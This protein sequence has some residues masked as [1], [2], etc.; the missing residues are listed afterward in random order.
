VHREHGEERP[1]HGRRER[2][3]DRLRFAGGSRGR[4]LSERTDALG[5]LFGCHPEARGPP[6]DPLQDAIAH[7]DDRDELACEDNAL[8]DEQPCEREDGRGESERRARTTTSADH[9][10]P[11][12][13]FSRP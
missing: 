4:L 13:G 1:E 8:R 6:T 7:A 11:S 10:T 5:Q 12:L 2:A 3:D 9:A